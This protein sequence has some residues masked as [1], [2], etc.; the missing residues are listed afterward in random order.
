[1]NNLSFLKSLLFTA[2]AGLMFLSCDGGGAIDGPT[3]KPEP[4]PPGGEVVPPE[5][6]KPD[7]PVTPSVEIPKA[8]LLDL[9]FYNDGSIKDISDGGMAV[10]NFAGAPMVNYY[11]G[12]YSMYVAHF[13]HPLGKSAGSGYIKADYSALQTVKNKLSDGHSIECLFRMDKASDG[14]AEVKMFSAM[15]SGGTGFLISNASRGTQITFL[16]N[17]STTGKS[18]WVWTYS[19]IVPEVGRY[20]HV[21]G[22]WNKSEQKTYIYVDGVLKGSADAPGEMVFPSSASSQWFGIGGDASTSNATNAWNGDVAVARVYDDPLTA[23]QVSALY[24]KVEA[25]SPKQEIIEVEDLSFLG[26]CSIKPQYR[27]NVYGT[28]FKSGDSLRLESC[29]N[30]NTVFTPSVKFSSDHLSLTVPYDFKGGLYRIMLIR[31]GVEYPLGSAQFRISDGYVTMGTQVVAHRALHNTGAPE[32]SIEAIKKA[33]QLEGLYASEIDV[34][35]TTD[36]EV[37]VN[38]DS[39]FPTDPEKHVIQNSTFADLSAV[40]LSNGESVP[41]LKDVLDQIQRSD[42]K[43]VIEIKSH[44]NNEKNFRCVDSCMAIVSRYSLDD[45][46]DWIAFNY[47]NCKRIAAARPQ[48]IVQYLNGDKAPSVCAADK[49]KGID[50]KMA[51]L[52]DEWITEAHS[53]GMVVNVWTVDSDADMLNY[54]GKQ[55]DFITTNNPQN[56]IA[57]LSKKYIELPE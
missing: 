56:C 55:V 32:N 53:L 43:L 20:Y 24:S 12:L 2:L 4:T 30:Q 22:V 14:S 10:T 15:Q 50:Y 41:R 45:K 25:S 52:K 9:V 5:P 26:E 8:D 11:N 1:M 35:V 3:E 39:T 57:L 31:G 28:G 16:P 13:N 36:G 21:V 40:R 48:A 17:I 44:E 47:D 19:S 29:D 51:K 27:Y 6:D 18:N 33:Q 23:E 37:V 38:H 7:E 54:I 42:M 46:V 49:I 34:W